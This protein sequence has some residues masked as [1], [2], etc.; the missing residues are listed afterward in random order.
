MLK[1]TE[2]LAENKKLQHLNLSWNFLN[3]KIVDKMEMFDKQEARWAERAKRMLLNW[4]FIKPNSK[5]E[6]L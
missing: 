1:I 2:V 5:N 3:R 6:H 4:K